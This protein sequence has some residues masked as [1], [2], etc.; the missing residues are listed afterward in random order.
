MKGN[1][2]S[3][4]TPKASSEHRM[5][6]R[7]QEPSGQG[8]WLRAR[9]SPH[10]LEEPLCPSVSHSPSSSRFIFILNYVFMKRGDDVTSGAHGS[11][12]WGQLL[13]SWSY[14]LSAGAKLGFSA[15]AA[16]ALNANSPF[17]EKET[18]YGPADLKLPHSPN[19]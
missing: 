2:A 12:K 4:Q 15:R 5:D 9:R 16:R 19:C 14:G 13:W 6:K 1:W 10:S 3:E 17:I 7:G 11:K 8:L 18:H